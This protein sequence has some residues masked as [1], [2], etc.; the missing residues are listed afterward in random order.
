MER[1]FMI[2]YDLPMPRVVGR[3]ASAWLK[4]FDTGSDTVGAN[5]N[6]KSQTWTRGIP[7]PHLPEHIKIY[8]GQGQVFGIFTHL[9]SHQM[10]QSYLQHLQLSG[11][12]HGSQLP[13]MGC[14]NKLCMCAEKRLGLSILSKTQYLYRVG[15]NTL[16]R[17]AYS[18]YS[19]SYTTVYHRSNTCFTSSPPPRVIPL[20]QPFGSKSEQ[21][22]NSG[23]SLF[24]A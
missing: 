21:G 2:Y 18:N 10:M 12:M 23:Y 17:W 9:P 8:E 24:L 16:G 7:S 5:A 13:G 22:Q 19:S 11:L 4:S 3:P 20:L 14:K 15:G 1:F 6:A